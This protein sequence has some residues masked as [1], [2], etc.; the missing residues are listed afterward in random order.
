[1]K[2]SLV[3][4]VQGRIGWDDSGIFGRRSDRGRERGRGEEKMKVH[5]FLNI[6]KFVSNV[7]EDKDQIITFIPYID[8]V[9]FTN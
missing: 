3:L 2:I 5:P 7:R 8:H 9:K 6:A 1:V 4:L